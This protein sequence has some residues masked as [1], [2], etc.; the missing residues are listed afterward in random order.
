MICR[1]QSCMVLEMGFHHGLR[2]GMDVGERRQRDSAHS[3]VEGVVLYVAYQRYQ[4]C[5]VPGPR[6]PRHV[7]GEEVAPRDV[8]HWWSKTARRAAGR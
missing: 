6:P 5:H 3:R 8:S 7:V 1:G 2:G 4:V